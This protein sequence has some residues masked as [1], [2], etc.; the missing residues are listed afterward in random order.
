MKVL[1]NINLNQNE[2]QNV[3]VQ[4]LATAPSTPKKG[5]IYFN[6][7][8]NKLFEYDG[9]NWVDLTAQG[10]TYT[11]SGGLTE[12][13]GTVTINNSVTGAT[14]CKITYNA[15][16]LVT[17]GADLASSD[18]PDLSSTYLAT[19]LKGAANGVAS[20]DSSGKV[21]SAQ[22]P[23]YVDDVVEGYY[24]NSKFYEE[25][26]HTTEITPE[27]GKI[28]VDLAED[29]SYRWGGS[30]YVEISQAT[31]HKYTETIT[32]DGTTTTFSI[33]HG[34]STLDVIVKVYDSTSNEDIIVDVVRNS[35]SVV[36]II[37]AQAPT[38]SNSYRVVVIA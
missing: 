7:T 23:S 15:Q 13:S 5:Q 28:Y 16:G 34:L 18:I 19:T 3:V 32:G 30:V 2:I 33:Q 8:S 12:S 4:N 29:K 37:F 24:Y 17:A 6:T 35:T 26:T 31:I 1:N 11:F 14:K 9:S 10:T 22:L 21:P 27:T 20:L 25:D 36:N 38:S